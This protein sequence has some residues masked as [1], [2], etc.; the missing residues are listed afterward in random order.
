MVRGSQLFLGMPTSRVGRLGFDPYFWKT[1]FSSFSRPEESMLSVSDQISQ[2][3]HQ[4]LKDTGLAVL[5]S[6]NRASLVGQLRNIAKKENC[7]RTIIGKSPPSIR[8]SSN[9]PGRS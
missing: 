4:G 1:L 7:I 6:E 3:I 5:S 8:N 2:E 9:M